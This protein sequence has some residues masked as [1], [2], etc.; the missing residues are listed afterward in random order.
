MYHITNVGQLSD[1]AECLL[2]PVSD[3][4]QCCCSRNCSFPGAL[5][6][7]SVVTAESDVL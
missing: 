4:L 1:S 3:Q 2:E 5:I 6:S 7:V